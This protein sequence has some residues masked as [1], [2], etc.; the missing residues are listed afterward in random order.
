MA[1]VLALGLLV[2]GRGSS[3]G[4]AADVDADDLYARLG[5]ERSCSKQDVQ[6]QYR[7]LAM[8][9]HPD[10]NKSHGAEAAFKRLAEA[11]EVLRDEGLRREYDAFGAATGNHH[12]GQEDD[13][14][15]GGHRDWVP[16]M[17][18]DA[19]EVFDEAFGGR[20]PFE[21][22][23]EFFSEDSHEDVRVDKGYL[24]QQQKAASSSCEDA[25]QPAAWSDEKDRHIA[26]WEIGEFDCT[27]VEIARICR[28]TC[29]LCPGATHGYEGAVLREDGT[30]DRDSAPGF[31][32]SATLDEEG[33][34]DITKT[35][36][37]T[38]E[39][40]NL[41]TRTLWKDPDG[42]RRATIEEK[43]TTGRV[44]T[45]SGTM[46]ADTTQQQNADA[47]A[48]GE[49]DVDESTAPI[50]QASSCDADEA[51][52][53]T[54]HPAVHAGSS[55]QEKIR[56]LYEMFSPDKL[57]NL[58]KI[59]AQYV[60]REDV[61]L[62]KLQ[63]R[64]EYYDFTATPTPD[65]IGHSDAIDGAEGGAPVLVSDDT[66]EQWEPEQR[67]SPLM[68]TDS[69][70]SAGQLQQ[71]EQ[72]EQEEQLQLELAMRWDELDKGW[73]GRP[74]WTW[75]TQEI[76]EWLSTV[77]TLPRAAYDEIQQALQQGAF[78][79]MYVCTY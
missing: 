71:Q 14:A 36:E 62:E 30:I 41:V 63:R 60:G 31:G 65:E 33:G 52:D 51:L 39:D 46:P 11:Y 1:S 53:S 19:F 5:L 3:D 49:R 70:T 77:E 59:M 56:A 17:F 69:G 47:D 66:Q 73:R 44:R 24:A 2:V 61:F 10:K 12:G 75:A 8:Q 23:D 72:D 29:G 40:G 43:G 25:N 27:H 13:D 79:A 54:D 28:K 50:Q 18:S 76:F 16:P 26:C 45:R 34:W 35:K 67:M 38:S 22:F 4:G 55:A 7:R 21:N 64:Y 20:D 78:F 9:F 68:H 57:H 15:R 6:K 37:I 42:S 32:F 74:F 48:D 58:G